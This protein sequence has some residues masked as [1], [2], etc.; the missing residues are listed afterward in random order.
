MYALSQYGLLALST[1]FASSAAGLVKRQSVASS[2]QTGWTYKGCY[3][4]SVSARV[5]S[6][7]SY[8]GGSMTEESCIAFCSKGGYPVSGTEYSGV[9]FC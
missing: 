7:S 3:T 5:L 2:P 8:S 6:A 1:V 4:D 9:F